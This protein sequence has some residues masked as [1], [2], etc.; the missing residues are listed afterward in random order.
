MYDDKK[1]A[2]A[3]ADTEHEYNTVYG[4]HVININD[5]SISM[6]KWTLK[7]ISSQELNPMCIGIDASNNE[8]IN[9]D[10]T[11]PFYGT[12]FYGALI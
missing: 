5:S 6:Y 1:I 10:F 12:P 8:R 4:N 3:D 11:N 9:A 7:L 2:R